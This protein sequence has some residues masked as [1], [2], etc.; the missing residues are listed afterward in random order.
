MDHDDIAYGIV[1]D[2]L[3]EGPVYQAIVDA[4]D[5]EGY[6]EGEYGD[7]DYAQVALTVRRTLTYLASHFNIQ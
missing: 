2:Y 3:A 7:D 6:D 4:V 5:D 1:Q